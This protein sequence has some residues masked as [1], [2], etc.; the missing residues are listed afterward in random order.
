LLDREGRL[1]AREQ[2]AT[3]ATLPRMD[4]AIASALRSYGGDQ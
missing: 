3:D 1:L 4:R 2:G